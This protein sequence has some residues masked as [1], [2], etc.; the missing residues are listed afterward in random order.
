MKAQAAYISGTEPDKELMNELQKLGELFQFNKDIAE[1]LMAEHAFYRLMGDL[2][3]ILGDA[4][5]IVLDF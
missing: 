1:Y 4:A 2:Y 3:K 5:E